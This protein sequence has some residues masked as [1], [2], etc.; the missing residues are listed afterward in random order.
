MK[1]EEIALLVKMHREYLGWKQINLAQEARLT[2]RTIQ[3][4]EA[5]EQMSDV[6]LRQ[7]AKAL[8]LSD[9]DYFLK[10]QRFPTSDELEELL[11]EWK[12]K[13]RIL[14]VQRATSGKQLADL[15]SRA[16]CWAFDHPEPETS[17]QKQLVGAFLDNLKDWG[18]ILGDLPPS[19]L[20]DATANFSEMLVDLEKSGYWVYVGER[21][22]TL[23]M[24]DGNTEPWQTKIAY[25][26]VRFAGETFEKAI[27]PRAASFT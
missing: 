8:K 2:E 12:R 16:H 15:A 24:K 4:L 5:G 14:D 27:I 1:P 17:E 26:F 3:R 25:V 10:P 18:D 9:P 11:S 7:V 13:Y 19:A 20:L 6:T 22:V 23:K 21:T